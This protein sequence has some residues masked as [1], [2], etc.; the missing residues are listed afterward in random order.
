[1]NSAIGTIE[2]SAAAGPTTPGTQAGRVS[3]IR[4]NS[5]RLES[6]SPGTTSSETNPSSVGTNSSSW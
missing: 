3:V 6:A 2:D 4:V 5:A 1:M